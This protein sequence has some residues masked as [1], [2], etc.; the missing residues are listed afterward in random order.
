MSA[1]VDERMLRIAALQTFLQQNHIDLAVMQFGTDLFYY[2]GSVHPLYLL[3]PRQ[4]QPMVLARKALERIAQEVAPLSCHSFSGTKDLL[5][6]FTRARLVGAKRIGFTLDTASYASVQRMQRMFP[7]AEL[8]DISW[9]IRM[10]RTVKSA[11]EI[12]IQMHAGEILSHVPE[13][14]NEYFNPGMSELELSAAL[15]YA[16]RR[17]GHD[18]LIRCRREGVEMSG[19]GVC[20]SG[21]NTLA[22]S[23]FDGIT[24]GS[25]LSSAV[26]YGATH[27][28][29]AQHVPIL[30][31][32][33]F[34]L[35]GYHVDQTRIACWGEVTDQV[36]EAYQAML[37]VEQAVFD[38]IHP[39]MLWEELYMV[40]VSRVADLGY[41]E[42]FMGIGKE[43]V[44]FVGHGVGLE[45]DEPP[46]LAQQM[47]YPLQEGMVM[48]IEPK[49]ALPGIGVVG[50]EDTVIVREQGIEIVTTCANDIIILEGAAPELPTS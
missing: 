33:A 16:F 40:A 11:S 14:A 27:T 34:V 17:N 29:I 3:V 24:G 31:D 2:C 20:A 32:F 37:Q 5:T 4:G 35:E 43:Q 6:L 23:K 26:P 19:C 9:D 18:A 46:F 36:T 22:G 41:S 8:V 38:S 50:I 15:E 25:G 13:W 47:P 7:G 45:L 1:L 12:A 44:R 42:F 10:L 49:V 39:G 48:A 28:A 21:E 30:L